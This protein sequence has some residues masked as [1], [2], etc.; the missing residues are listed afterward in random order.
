MQYRSLISNKRSY[1]CII[2]I[3]ALLVLSFQAFASSQ[4]EW[5]PIAPGIDYSRLKPFSGPFNGYLHVFKINLNDYQLELI[6][7]SELEK[8][9]ATIQELTTKA[10]GLLGINGGFFGKNNLPL[11]LRISKGNLKNRTKQISWWAIF[12][13]T[14][15]Q[16][17]I[18]SLKNFKNSSNIEFAIQAGPRLVTHGLPLPHL[19]D[20]FDERTALGI[21]PNGEIILVSSDNLLMNTEQ[22]ANL[23][24]KPQSEGGL[25]CVDALNLDGGSSSQLY[26]HINHFQLH[27]PGFTSVADAVIVKKREF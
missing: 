24:A 12:Y 21:L 27:I 14:H 23:M 26:A 8:E 18:D 19:K 6:S 20:G 9:L 4:V 1:Y 16:A 25:G 17:Y 13:I 11:G 5:E 7:A 10:K 2:F 22:L 15:H 3:F